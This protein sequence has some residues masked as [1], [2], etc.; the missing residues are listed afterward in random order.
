M[1]TVGS[2]VASVEEDGPVGA[3][4][5]AVV[6]EIA[7]LEG[8]LL[9]EVEVVER[10]VAPVGSNVGRARRA[11]GGESGRAESREPANHDVD[12]GGNGNVLLPKH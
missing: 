12:Q 1:E 3:R 6:Q 7:L 9:G 10:R 11:H 8:A 5:V 4:P 2:L